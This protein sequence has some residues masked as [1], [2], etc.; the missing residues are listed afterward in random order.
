MPEPTSRE[1]LDLPLPPGNP[2]GATTVRGYLI[3]LLHNLWRDEADFN[4]KRPFG[5]SGWAFDLYVPMVKAGMVPGV[6]SKDGYDE[7]D[8]FD[9]RP[10]DRLILAAILSLGEVT[11]AT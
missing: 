7:L 11:D 6:L 10:A 5:Y 9:Y 8:E 2:S 3:K 1:L 4:S